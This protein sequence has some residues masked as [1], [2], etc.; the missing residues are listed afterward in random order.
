MHEHSADADTVAS[1]VRSKIGEVRAKLRS[2]SA[3]TGA[4]D[5]GAAAVDPPQLERIGEAYLCLTQSGLS[6]K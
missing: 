6:T 4:F 5:P 1:R 2:S 3:A